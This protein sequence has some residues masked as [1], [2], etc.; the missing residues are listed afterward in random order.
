MFRTNARLNC[1]RC[2]G[3]LE[4][5]SKGRAVVY[6]CAACGGVW[7]DSDQAACVFEGWPERAALVRL[8]SAVADD[9]PMLATTHPIPRC[10]IDREPLDLCEARGVQIDMCEHGTWFDAYEL[11]RIAASPPS[12]ADTRASDGIVD[13]AI[14]A[15][16]ASLEQ[17]EL[18]RKL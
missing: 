6:G 9:S 8:S 14:D 15:V 3:E 5:R 11:R 7:L 1:P 2:D 16:F 4:E 12:A 17:A 18:R 10:P 13:K